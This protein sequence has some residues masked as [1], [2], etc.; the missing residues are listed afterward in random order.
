MPWKV[1]QLAR[2]RAVCRSIRTVEGAVGDA[3]GPVR[4]YHFEELFQLFLRDRRIGDGDQAFRLAQHQRTILVDDNVAE[5]QLRVQQV[6]DLLDQRTEN[7][8]VFVF[9]VGQGA[10]LRGLVVFHLAVVSSISDKI[11]RLIIRRVRRCGEERLQAKIQKMMRKNRTLSL[12]CGTAARNPF[13]GRSTCARP[14]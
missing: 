4:L 11:V 7:R 8:M 12:I 6:Q 10:N 14:G 9:D 3:L 2:M 1:K 5:N 13:S